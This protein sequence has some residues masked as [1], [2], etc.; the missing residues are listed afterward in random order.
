MTRA[1]ALLRAA[2]APDLM[3]AFAGSLLIALITFLVL[4]V[5]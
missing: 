1:L 5:L 4:E 3:A 2:T